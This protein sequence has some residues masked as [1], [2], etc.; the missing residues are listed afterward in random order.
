MGTGSAAR[1]P[2]L[3]RAHGGALPVMGRHGALGVDRGCCA[4]PP[5]ARRMVIATHSEHPSITY[6]STFQETPAHPSRCP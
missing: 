6:S 5:Y 3:V 1:R 2:R 4:A